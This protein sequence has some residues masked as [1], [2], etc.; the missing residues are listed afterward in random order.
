MGTN[1]EKPSD[2]ISIKDAF[3]LKREINKQIM[4]SGLNAKQIEELKDL[5]KE[6]YKEVH[7]H[8]SEIKKSWWIFPDYFYLILMILSA[9][10]IIGFSKNY[11][12]IGIAFGVMVLGIYKLSYRSGLLEGYILGYEAGHEGGVLKVL[13]IS[14]KEA[15][16][17]HERSIEMQ[18]DERI[19]GNFDKKEE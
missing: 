3:R 10:C 19:I 4:Y 17:I 7:R 11:P 1:D 13:G 14:S 8:L 6:Q 18:M 16:D 15:K 2:E 5:T 9:L 12:I